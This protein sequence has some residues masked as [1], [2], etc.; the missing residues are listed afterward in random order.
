MDQVT[1]KDTNYDASQIQVLEGLEAVRKR[2]GM[3]IGS[4]S[5][6]GLHHLV[7]EIVDNSI[8]EALAGYCDNIEVVIHPDNSVSVTDNGRGI[9]TG[10]HEKTGK[11]TV[12]TVLTVLHAGGKFGGGG[13][14]VSG[15][16]HGVGSS[17]VNAL[18]EW[19]EVEVK[20]NGKVH[21]MRF[22]V[23]VPE[24]DLA[25]VGETTE[26]GTKV[27]FKPDPTIFTETTVFDYEVLQKRIRE[28]AFLN[29]GLRI[30]LKD[31]R[32]GQEREE[33]FHYEGGIVQFVE[34]LNK[35]REP[36]HE[37]VI[38]CEGEKDGLHVEVAIQYNDSYISNIY[39]FANNIN[40]HEGG[41]HESGFKTALTRVINDYCR[42]FN[43]LKEK[44]PNLSG[45]DVREGITAII[46]VKIPE[47]Q[48]EGQTKTKLGN[49][50]ARSVTESVFGDRFATFMEENPAVAKRIVEKALMA[51]RA[52]EAARKARELTRRKSA[53]EVSALPG[54]LADCSSKDASE[55]E[56][57]IV[58]GDSAGGSAKAGR[59]RHFQAILPLRGKVLNVEK[60][61]LDKILANN[62]IRAIITALGTGVGEDFDIS[63]ARYHKVVIMT[64]ADVD[65]SHIRTLLLTLFYRYMRPLIEAGYIYIAQPPLYSIKQ[66]K[67]IYYAYND[68]QRDEILAT[69]K[70]TPKPSIQRYKGLGEMNADQL[71]ETTM[72]PEVRTLLQVSL[73]DAMEADMVF[74]T[75]MGDDVEPRREF[76]EQYAATVRDL[77][78]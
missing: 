14:K 57:F 37:E 74:E 48:F 70:S 13:Y 62:E 33:S 25:V 64:D 73:E 72:D 55:S 17:V 20:Q 68:K 26:T 29:K 65:G 36:L 42:K 39:S 56:L 21:F 22:N 30:T 58:E 12:E 45:D 8:D 69:L 3:Y 66:G 63:K 31:E 28:L 60:S 35:N 54:K 46:S 32:P 2:P 38:Y 41:T 23:G 24:A 44:D 77:D 49:S 6:R 5:S 19:L 16:L 1:T 67:Q 4:T 61:R 76:I 43:F 50:E 51:A 18:S 34:Y 27:T 9:P 47:P 7:W 78:I 71:W 53:L 59:D 10:I 52:R 15:G 40:T 75:L 11:S